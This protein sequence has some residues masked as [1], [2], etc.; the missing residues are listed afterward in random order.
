MSM[1][2]SRTT[3]IPV[4]IIGFKRHH[5]IALCIES[6]RRISPQQIYLAF[7]GARNID[8]EAEV[9]KT[10][11][12][13]LCLIDWTT[14]IRILKSDVNL[15]CGSFPI[16]AI[17]WFFNNEEQ[18]IVLEEDLILD[19]L[20]I[21]FISHV[22]KFASSTHHL[23]PGFLVTACSYLTSASSKPNMSNPEAISAFLTRIPNIWGW[24]TTSG[25]WKEFLRYQ[26]VNPNKSLNTFF[27]L[28]PKLSLMQSLLFTLC[29]RLVKTGKL[30]TWDYQF[31]EFLIAHNIHT[32]NPT[33]NL[34]HNIGYGENSTH[35]PSGE[36]SPTKQLLLDNYRIAISSLY[37]N[38]RY[39]SSIAL[40]TPWKFEYNIHI[41][42]GLLRLVHD[43]IFKSFTN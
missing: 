35:T 17:T 8:E 7:D 32:V 10:R 29:L 39:Q 22:N 42:K 9:L 31:A 37:H 43:K 14:R 16:K 25:V 21:D 4:L 20:F 19:P 1:G 24:Y 34:I 36:T 28:F 13:A 38:R 33:H 18:G 11:T 6:L 40:N 23:K 15:G 12:K 27:S 2:S 26:L 41:L 5:E 30:D 3:S